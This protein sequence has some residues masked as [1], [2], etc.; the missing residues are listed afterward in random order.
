MRERERLIIRNCTGRSMQDV[1]DMVSAVVSGGRLSGNGTEYCY[2]TTFKNGAFCSATRN[3][4]SDTLTFYDE[5]SVS[6]D[7]PKEAQP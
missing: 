1:L 7:A 3:K 6:N 4:R 5:T 2:L